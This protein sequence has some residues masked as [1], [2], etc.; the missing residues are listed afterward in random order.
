MGFLSDTLAEGLTDGTGW[1]LLLLVVVSLAVRLT[2]GSDR[3]LLRAPWLLMALHLLLVPAAGLLALLQA[4]TRDEVHLAALALALLS[5]INASTV[6]VFGVALPWVGLRLS[7]IF[8]DVATAVASVIAIFS[9]LSRAGFNVSGIVAT[10][11]VLTAVIGFSLKDTLGNVIGGLALHTDKS[12]SIGDWIKVGDVAG[13]VVEIRWRYTAVETRNWET[14]IVPNGVITGEKVLVLGRRRGKPQQWRRWVW[15][16]VDY[17]FSPEL[18]IAAVDQALNDAPIENVAADPVPHCVLMDL[19]ES[20]GRYAARYWLTDLFRDDPTDS[21]VRRRI[22]FALERAGIPLSMARQ[23]LF[24]HD[25]EKRRRQLEADEQARRYRAVSRIDL[26]RPLEEEDRRFLAERLHYAPFAPNEVLTHQGAAGHWLYLVVDGEASARVA[27]DGSLEKEV[28]RLHPGDFFGE[29]ALLTGAP[30]TATVVAVTPVEAYRLDAE[31]F[32]EI[33]HRRPSIAEPVAEI[34]A[35]RRLELDAVRGDLDQEAHR[36]RLA[37]AKVDLLG[38]IRDFFKLSAS[39][40]DGL[41]RAA[42]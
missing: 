35:R 3:S 10:S 4:A 14:L 9:L 6:L 28:A 39:P 24:L 33:I 18:V 2:P 21:V 5:A 11:A 13:R 41:R 20:F 36:R 19:H 23:E 29:M 8:Q 27:A 34:L 17:R 31:A 42:H 32:R 12:I 16:N 15:F 1:V 37:A 7:R 30:R 22:Y 38:K 25:E 26:F 40:E